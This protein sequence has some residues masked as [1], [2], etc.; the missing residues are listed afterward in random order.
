MVDSVKNK[1]GYIRK[2]NRQFKRYEESV[3][4]LRAE[5]GRVKENK[6]ELEG[7]VQVLQ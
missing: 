2:V 3:E 5:V 6:V 1:D 4:G 7:K